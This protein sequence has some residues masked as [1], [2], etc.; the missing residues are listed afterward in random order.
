M[1]RLILGNGPWQLI[2]AA[3]AGR[4]AGPDAAG[5]GTDTVGLYAMQ[6]GS[7]IGQTAQHFAEV[8]FPEARCLWLNEQLDPPIGSRAELAARCEA[9][10]DAMGTREAA[11]VWLSKLFAPAEKCVLAAYPAAALQLYEEGLHFYVPQPCPP[12]CDWREAGAPHLWPRIVRA[13]VRPRRWPVR[14]IAMNGLYPPHLA[15]VAGVWQSP[16]EDVRL[17][18]H[19]ARM[20]ARRVSRETLLG[21]LDA[22]A[23]PVPD[24]P[25]E[26]PRL[27]VL[28]QC[29][30]RYGILPWQAEAAFYERSVGRI[31]ARGYRVWW[32]EHPRTEHAF[33]PALQEAFDTGRVRAFPLEAPWPVELAATRM[34]LA[35]CAAVSSSAL[36]YLRDLFGLP[37]YTMAEPTLTRRIR[38]RDM[39]AVIRLTVDCIPPLSALEASRD[40]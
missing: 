8:L 34:P 31:L 23:C 18:G 7:A 5:N 22:L 2:M 40:D 9:L 27:L 33:L 15:R 35:G 29:F 1:K 10:Y 30:Y 32:K 14:H 16:A 26:P 20:P 12:A 21:V 13:G 19:L 3:A 6:P 36:F 37:T 38:Y 11:E 17:P 24:L 39:Q 4:Q 25:D 28:G